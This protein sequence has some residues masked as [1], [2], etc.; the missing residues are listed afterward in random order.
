M[1]LTLIIY[2]PARFSHYNYQSEMVQYNCTIEHISL[3]VA[4]NFSMR[5]LSLHACMDMKTKGLFYFA[6]LLP[7]NVH[8][9]RSLFAQQKTFMAPSIKGI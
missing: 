2:L 4:T 3:R 7:K 5:I 8:T 6:S 1:N 9:S